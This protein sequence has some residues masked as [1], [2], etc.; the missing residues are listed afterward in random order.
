MP[1]K[2][3]GSA[4]PK[5]AKVA[6]SAKK[7]WGCCGNANCHCGEFGKKLI[8]TLFG[9]LLAYC[10]VFLGTV[11]RNN[12]QKY[13]FI[14]KAD[15]MERMITIDAKGKVTAKPDIAVVSLGMNTD[16]VTVADA[17]KKNTEVMNKLIAKV[18][19]LGVA[20]DDIKTAN[21]NIYPQYDYTDGGS[22]LKGYQVSQ[23]VDVKIRNLDNANKILAIA[24]EVGANNV[25]GL[26]FTIDDREVYK[27]QA[28]KEAMDKLAIKAKEISQ[29]LGVRLV[30]IVSY[31]EYED[32]GDN[33]PVYAMSKS[34]GMGGSAEAVPAPEIQTGSM[35]VS[36]NVNVTFEIR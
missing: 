7:S 9:I 34:M 36:L 1:V 6:V 12:M 29:S 24:G 23:S 13:N 19:E 25:G 11:V 8:W 5:E 28:R 27:A 30:S 22:K 15:K 16:A 3:N 18:K 2:Q 4:T 17:Q 14:G 21:Y 35:D 20:E 33:Y 31:N 26:Q 32:T 10:I